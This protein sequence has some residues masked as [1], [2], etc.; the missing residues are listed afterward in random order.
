MFCLFQQGLFGGSE[1][2]R[3]WNE[4]I[5]FYRPSIQQLRN[6]FKQPK[7]KLRGAPMSLP[8]TADDITDEDKHGLVII[9]GELSN[10]STLWCK[11]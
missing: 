11:K 7:P 6:S 2:Y 4:M 10:L 5:L 3:I 1:E 9:F 8:E